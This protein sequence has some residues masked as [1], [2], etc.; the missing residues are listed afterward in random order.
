MDT[1]K[2][3]VSVIVPVY[4]AERYLE[5]CLDSLLIQTYNNFEII[6]I[7]DGSKDGSSELCDRY[8]SNNI[9]V[10]H[11][12]NQG[13][14]SARNKGIELAKGEFMV[15][16]DS[17]DS[18]DE[19]Y[20]SKLVNKAVDCDLA[21]SGYYKVNKKGF[22]V[23]SSIRGEKEYIEFNR[24]EY[25]D[26]LFTGTLGYQ[27]YLWNKIFKTKTIKENNILFTSRI[28]YNEDRL[29]ILNYLMYCHKI[30]FINEPLYLYFQ[31]ENSA[32]GRIQS[33]FNEKMITELV[34]YDEMVSMLKK[35]KLNIGIALCDAMVAL[36]KMKKYI[37]KYPKIRHYRRRWLVK[38]VF[39]D[40]ILFK[41]KIKSIIKSLI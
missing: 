35:H 1:F 11:Q 15:V 25:I 6:L 20:L 39:A 28:Y 31:N 26:L 8:V 36:R 3:L 14:S 21:V 30:T 16:V 13:V 17:D 10:F 41:K 22:V 5:K 24:D 37:K 9:H 23:S 33:E 32:M 40:E 4:N 18:V 27:G 38:L 2:N 7:D 34:A 29:F 19:N 12:E